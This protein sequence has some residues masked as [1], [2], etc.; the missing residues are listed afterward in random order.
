MP[1]RPPP[2]AGI[3]EETFGQLQRRLVTDM[4]RMGAV[5]SLKHVTFDSFIVYA[6]TSNENAPAKVLARPFMFRSARQLVMM[7][8]GLDHTV[9]RLLEAKEISQAG[10]NRVHRCKWMGSPTDPASTI[11]TFHIFAVVSYRKCAIS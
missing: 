6:V 5:P 8:S 3:G 10:R 11:R 4:E 7:N 9:K 2:P 1:S